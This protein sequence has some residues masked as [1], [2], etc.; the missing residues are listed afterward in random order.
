MVV[1][2]GYHLLADC[3]CGS[4]APAA[5]IHFARLAQIHF[6]PMGLMLIAN[7]D[8]SVDAS[9]EGSALCLCLANWT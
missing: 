3:C 8:Y 4:R 7:C 9:G 6:A 1:R 2:Q 5:Q